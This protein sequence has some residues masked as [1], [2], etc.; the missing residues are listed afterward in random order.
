MAMP[1]YYQGLGSGGMNGYQMGNGGAGTGVGF[2]AG[3]SVSAGSGSGTGVAL[4]AIL[5]GL[6]VFYVMTRSIQGSR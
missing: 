5:G 2:S 4:L 1:F 3:T 6:V